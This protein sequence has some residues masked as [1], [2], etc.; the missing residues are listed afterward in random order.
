MNDNTNK[1][2]FPAEDSTAWYTETP[3]VKRIAEFSQSEDGLCIS[4]SDPKAYGL[5]KWITE[6]EIKGGHTY[7]ISVGARTTS[8]IGDIYALFT[9]MDKDGNWLIREHI[10]NAERNGDKVDFYEIFE[11]PEDGARIKL[12]LWL[13]GYCAEVKWYN[14]TLVEW[15][16]QQPRNVRVALA[17]IAPNYAPNI[18]PQLNKETI[19]KA[20][21]NAGAHKPDIIV[22]G[23]TMYDTSTTLTLKEA[24]Q[25]DDG[26]MCTIIRK[27]AVEY[28]SYIIYNFHE[29]ENGEYYNTSIL[30]DRKGQTVGK[31]RKNQLTVTEYEQGMTPGN[32]YPVFDTDFGKIGI[33]ICW[34]HYF[35]H[36]AQEVVNNGA[37]IVFVSSAGDAAQKFFARAMDTGVHFAVCG[38]NTENKY[39]WAPA[40]VVNP[41]GEVLAES[42][43]NTVP[44]VCDIDLNERVRRFWLSV[45]P[46]Q[47]QYKGDY[48]FEKDH[49]GPKNN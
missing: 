21:D 26:E 31:Y 42:S 18:T 45:G 15:E 23:E 47:S 20:V 2:L 46:A 44:A 17:Y 40:R 37:E 29:E 10:E 3:E 35:P 13:K 6:T 33:L 11:V 24:A 12:E 34:D 16:K 49:E 25:N 14:P 5:G 19:V 48:R 9:V 32:G 38:W 7:K 39:G 1:N 36:T 27:K 43:E 8:C 41:H 4:L 28:N 22:L 30:I